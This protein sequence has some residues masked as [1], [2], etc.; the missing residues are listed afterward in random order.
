M[1]KILLMISAILICH[2]LKRFGWYIDLFDASLLEVIEKY[3]TN[4]ILGFV[5]LLCMV[6]KDFIKIVARDGFFDNH[7]LKATTLS[8]MIFGCIVF[9]SILWLI[10]P[11][12]EQYTIYSCHN[13]CQDWE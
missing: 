5:S 8:K 9:I 2:F 13:E 3:S 4:A 11:T 1:K 7:D 12:V 10:S 6:N